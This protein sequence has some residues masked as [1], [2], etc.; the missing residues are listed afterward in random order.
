MKARL[1]AVR[2]RGKL[3]SVGRQTRKGYSLRQG[4][5]PSQLNVEHH[6]VSELS[7]LNRETVEAPGEVLTQ[8]LDAHLRVNACEAFLTPS[9]HLPFPLSPIDN[10]SCNVL[11]GIGLS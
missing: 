7:N 10:S 2:K 4:Q 9:G 5:T 6:L 1:E 8:R 3:H 11:M